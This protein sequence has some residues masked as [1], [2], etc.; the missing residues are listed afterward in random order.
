MSPKEGA[1]TS[2][3]DLIPGGSKKME[4]ERGRAQGG[5]VVRR[6]GKFEVKFAKGFVS[7]KVE[8]RQLDEVEIHTTIFPRFTARLAC[9]FPL[10]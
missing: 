3:V 2:A 10:G 1:A 6:G 9:V 7:D 8:P 5:N 4:W